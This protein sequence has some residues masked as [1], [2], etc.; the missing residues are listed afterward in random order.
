LFKD[1]NPSGTGQHVQKF[2]ELAT[3]LGTASTAL[4]HGDLGGAAT[5]L[6]AAAAYHGAQH[7]IA[8]GMTSPAMVERL[9]TPAAAA[10]AAIKVPKAFAGVLPLASKKN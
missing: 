3:P 1:A 4:L 2:A 5:E 10:K 7:L 8:K 9:M 6:G